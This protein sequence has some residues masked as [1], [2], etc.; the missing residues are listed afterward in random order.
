MREIPELQNITYTK[1]EILRLVTIE[2][3]RYML[4][5]KATPKTLNVSSPNDIVMKQANRHKQNSQT[6]LL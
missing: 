4:F 3:S 2:K 5:T 6:P 1:T